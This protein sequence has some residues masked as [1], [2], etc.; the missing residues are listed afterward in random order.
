MNKTM[1]KVL[2]IFLATLMCITSLP[3]FA[4]ADEARQ[5]REWFV[6]IANGSDETGTGTIDKPFKTLQKGADML[7]AGD[8]LYIREGVYDEF[9]KMKSSG[10]AEAPITIKPYNDEE[11]TVRATTKLTNWGKKGD[12]IW[13]T[14]MTFDKAAGGW[15]NDCLF[16]G[17]TTMIV[18]RYP[19]IPE[20]GT[21]MWP[22]QLEM[23]D[24]KRNSTELT[25]MGTIWDSE[26][27]EEDGYWDGAK[28][29]M[30]SGLNWYNVIADVERYEKGILYLIDHDYPDESY[31]LEKAHDKYYIKDHIHCLDTVNEYY[32]DYENKKVYIYSEENPNQ[33]EIGARNQK[34]VFD[35]S[36]VGYINF[37]GFNIRGAS[38]KHNGKTH[39]INYEWMS[40][41]GFDA[42]WNFQ[43]AYNTVKHSHLFDAPYEILRIQ[44]GEYNAIFNCLIENTGWMG[45][46]SSGLGDSPTATNS[47]IAYNTMT[48]AGRT[49]FAGMGT[50]SVYE[51][52][53]FYNA[54]SLTCDT[55]ITYTSGGGAGMTEYRYNWLHD[56]TARSTAFGLYYDNSGSSVAIHHNVVWDNDNDTGELKV[57]GWG[58]ILLNDPAEA[59]SVYN[60]TF[61]GDAHSG[62]TMK[63]TND[64]RYMNN[65]FT[66]EIQAVVQYEEQANNLVGWLDPSFVDMR[67]YDFRLKE[68]SIAIDNGMFIEGVTDNY[69]GEAP[70]L[71]AY[72]YGGEYWIPGHNWENPPEFVHQTP[73]YIKWHNVVPQASFEDDQEFAPSRVGETRMWNP[74]KYG[75][76]IMKETQGDVDQEF[77]HSLSVVQAVRRTGNIGVKLGNDQPTPYPGDEVAT[78]ATDIVNAY[79]DLTDG[80]VNYPTRKKQI[81]YENI[82][83]T[84]YDLLINSVNML[85]KGDF[86]DPAYTLG[87]ES[88][89]RTNTDEEA[90]AGSRSLKIHD[91]RYSWSGMRQQLPATEHKKLRFSVAVKGDEGSYLDFR[92]HDHHPTDWDG[93]NDRYLGNGFLN[94][95]DT[96]WNILAFDID[97]KGATQGIRLQ[98]NYKNWQGGSYYLDNLTMID[99]TE[100]YMMQEACAGNIKAKAVVDAAIANKMLTAEEY[101]T[102]MKTAAEILLAENKDKAIKL[103][104]PILKTMRNNKLSPDAGITYTSTEVKPG[105]EYKLTCHAWVTNPN[106]K[107]QYFVKDGEKI[108]TQWET[109]QQTW[110]NDFI[111]FTAPASGKV[112]VEIWKPQGIGS[113]HVDDVRIHELDPIVYKK[114]SGAKYIE[115]N[116][117]DYGELWPWYSFDADLE[118]VETDK[119]HGTA[120]KVTGGRAMQDVSTLPTRK[121]FYVS[122]DLK[123]AMPGVASREAEIN[124]HVMEG[125][126]NGTYIT[127]PMGKETITNNGWTHIEGIL[128]VPA[129]LQFDSIGYTAGLVGGDGVFLLDN[130]KIEE[131]PMPTT[132][133]TGDGMTFEQIMADNKGWVSTSGDQGMSINKTYVGST[134]GNIGYMNESFRDF[135]ITFQIR[136]EGFHTGNYPS[137][138][139]RNT[140][141]NPTFTS[142]YTFIIKDGNIEL[143]KY[144]SGITQNWLF[145]GEPSSPTGI[146]GPAVFSDAFKMGEWNTIRM[147]TRNEE[148]GVRIFFEVN[149]EVY[150]D[151]MDVV[152]T[153]DNA[154]TI[155]FCRNGVDR[156]E[157]RTVQK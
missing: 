114:R 18:A 154:G 118:L 101:A 124:I 94:I 129:D 20:G 24:A 35:V 112:T 48:N 10:T 122:G 155:A 102:A 123:L 29:H 120:L 47:Y 95:G 42:A 96:D 130:A 5:P 90:Y 41:A 100:L 58:A 137:I 69:V 53:H 73:N 62:T 117:M 82:P 79:E 49:C 7:Q 16:D 134:N 89:G 76:S 150:Y 144:G 92:L 3:L 66:G 84:M 83:Q 22:V 71:G 68:D 17:E 56:M 110:T 111:T 57:D 133:G 64:G 106:D 38:P 8:T 91:M 59:Y 75:W 43:G 136:I 72:E 143:Q 39:H 74:D 99:I 15:T 153:V 46:G 108:L 33:K 146:Y 93:K 105:R 85:P 109:N 104:V 121:S 40:M 65:I 13:V 54:G 12:N 70:D 140:S 87:T 67:N 149:G 139:M 126:S 156:I 52:N 157:V 78:M 113:A 77:F 37:E 19:N 34:N 60:N 9:F 63:L 128:E 131:M 28:V 141:A 103:L 127:Y 1:Q 98:M 147:G 152:S 107:V 145:V 26:L 138:T 61:I 25:R 115:N 44:N 132:P 55:G 31:Y 151:Y 36:D 23:D 142:G 50:N 45:K 21:V 27:T 125:K 81:L 148:K 135:E 51:Y 80:L 119:E 6:S 2:S 97:T 116:E 14:D 88:S 32:I 4:V 30:Q 11:V 86:E